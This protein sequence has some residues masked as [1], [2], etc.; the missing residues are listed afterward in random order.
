MQWRVSP[1]QGSYTVSNAWRV[2]LELVD[3]T[4]G[5]LYTEDRRLPILPALYQPSLSNGVIHVSIDQADRWIFTEAAVE[6]F[7]GDANANA[8]AN[9]YFYL[10]LIHI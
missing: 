3:T 2:P 6:P 7:L 1:S 8:N 4:G 10:S 5:V 9:L